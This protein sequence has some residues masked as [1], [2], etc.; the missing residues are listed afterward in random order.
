MPASHDYGLPC[1]AAARTTGGAWRLPDAITDQFER[2]DAAGEHRPDRP[3]HPPRHDVIV[4]AVGRPAIRAATVLT[5][6][7]HG[8]S[9]IFGACSVEGRALTWEYWFPHIGLAVDTA[10]LPDDE[11]DAKCAW[12]SER[13]II[14]CSRQ[15]NPSETGAVNLALLRHVAAERLGTPE[16]PC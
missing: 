5:G 9:R 2:W 6:L 3:E 16:L 13:D 11:A 14:Y 7:S 4:A 12:A 8:L 1:P 15:S 10:L